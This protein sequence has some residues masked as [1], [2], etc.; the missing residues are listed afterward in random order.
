MRLT[1]HCIDKASIIPISDVIIG[2]VMD[3]RLFSVSHNFDSVTCFCLSYLNS[4][5]QIVE[6]KYDCI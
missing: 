6:Y 1:V 2:P 3:G 5:A 4:V